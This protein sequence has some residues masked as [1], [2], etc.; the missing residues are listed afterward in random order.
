[1]NSKSSESGLPF[2]TRFFYGWIIVGVSAL[3]LFFS[4]PGQTYSVSIFIDSFIVEFNWSRSIVSGVY[5]AGTLLAGFLMGIM[6]SFFDRRGHRVM[7]TIVAAL[8]GVACIWMSYVANVAMLFFGFFLIRLLGQ[9]SLSLSS[10]T[11]PPQWFIRKKGRA[12]SIVSIGG[13]LSSALLPPVNTWLINTFGWRL[14]WRFWA[15]LLWAFMVPVSHYLIRNKPEDVGLTPDTQKSAQMPTIRESKQTVLRDDWLLKEVF[16][17][18]AFWLLLYCI[19]VPSA[20]TTGLIFHHVSISSQLG[21]TEE[22]AA[23]ILSIMALIRFPIIFVV[24]QLADRVPPR[25]LMAFNQSILL[26]GIIVLY[27][28]TDM[29][30]A[31][32]YGIL[33]GVMMAFQSITSSVVWPEY[34]GRKYLGSIRGISLM[35]GVL[36]SA[37]GPLPY[38]FTYDLWGSYQPILLIS[39][40]FPVLGILAALI[41][42]PPKK[43]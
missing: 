25:F 33:L 10:M 6:G 8:L 27:F 37:L 32:L 43:N 13:A 38:G 23:L 3:I 30:F 41:A 9:G 39:L 1:M 24:G 40:A 35:A 36:G 29:R 5:S 11:L 17:T 16:R 19:A 34:F 42:A 26:L 12:L 21:L 15:I 22:I 4:G 20:I 28:A 18:R 2:R 7:T 31:L 14:G